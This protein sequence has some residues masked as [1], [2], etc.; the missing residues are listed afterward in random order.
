MTTLTYKLI[1]AIETISMKVGTSTGGST[2]GGNT[3]GGG[4]SGGNTGD[5]QGGSSDNYQDVNDQNKGTINLV[6]QTLCKNEVGA[7]CSGQIGWNGKLYDFTVTV[8]QDIIGATVV[9]KTDND[10]NPSNVKFILVSIKN[11]D[12]QYVAIKFTDATTA[13][14]YYKNIQCSNTSDF[15]SILDSS[16]VTEDKVIST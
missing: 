13:E 2:S 4:S 6:C 9:N 12:G 14:L 3:Q 16:I 5:T 8:K 7:H 15:M 10:T 1:T 11:R